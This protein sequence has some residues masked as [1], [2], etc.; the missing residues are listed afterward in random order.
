MWM[1]ETIGS[2]LPVAVGVAI[3]PIPIIAVILMLFTT[4]AK[5][6]SLAFLVG[7]IAGILI[8]GGIVL[9]IANASSL[10]STDDE[11][12]TTVGVIKLLFGLLLL[13]L[14]G[15]NWRGRPRAGEE[16]QTPGWMAAIDSFSAVKSLGL[17]VLLSGINP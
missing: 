6:N 1:S 3:S 5:V 9:G 17:A 13:L 8:S 2:I 10:A 4:R 11:P 7:W 15:R 16:P 14:A 12:S